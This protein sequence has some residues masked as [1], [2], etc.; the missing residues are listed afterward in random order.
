MDWLHCNLCFCQPGNGIGYN[1]T[2]CG[3]IYCEK[4][5]KEGC[6]NRCKMC[7]AVCTAMKLTSKLKP[8][9]ECFFMDPIDLAKKHNKQLMQVMDFQRSHRKRLSSY[10]RE[11]VIHLIF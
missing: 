1:L 4:C 10:I 3:H 5:V 2:N 11:K 8:E 9:V 7:G 6:E